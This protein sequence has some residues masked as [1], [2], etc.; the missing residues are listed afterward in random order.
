MNKENAWDQNNEIAIVE[1]SVEE[2]SLEEITIAMK[3]MK[4]GKVSGCS[5]VSLEMI[6]ISGKVGIDMMMKLFQRVLGGNRIPEDCKTS[7]MVP[8]CM[9]KGDVT[10]CGSHRR[11]KLLEH[12]IKIIE[13]VLEKRIRE[14]VKVDDMQFDFIPVRRMI[15]ALFIERRM[16]ENTGRKRK[17]K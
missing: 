13:R 1:D 17:K 3:K 8:I 16:Q 15:D 4:L 9:G 10:N 6:N 7:V 2:V 14:L 5:K 12:G 11:I